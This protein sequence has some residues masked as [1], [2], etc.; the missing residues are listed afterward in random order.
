MSG[1]DVTH[2]NLLFYASR[3]S[4]RVFALA[5]G[6]RPEPKTKLYLAPYYNVSAEGNVCQ[7]TAHVPELVTPVLIPQ[8]EK[9]F[10]ESAFTHSNTQGDRL[11]RYKGIGGHDEFWLAMRSPSGRRKK[12]DP[13]WLMSTGKTVKQLIYL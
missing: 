6:E 5:K 9:A 13:K 2:P 10:F 7:G 4:L 11:I 1:K 8:M 12:I 3:S